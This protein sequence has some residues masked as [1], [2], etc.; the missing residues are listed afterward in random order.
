MI[1]FAGQLRWTSL[2]VGSKSNMQ[3]S[4]LPYY[5][6]FCFALPCGD[7]LGGRF[8]CKSTALL[9]GLSATLWQCSGQ[10]KGRRRRG[11]TVPGSLQSQATAH[12]PPQI[13]DNHSG[14]EVLM[15]QRCL[16]ANLPSRAR[17]SPEIAAA[18]NLLLVLTALWNGPGRISQNTKNKAHMKPALTSLRVELSIVSCCAASRHISSIFPIFHKVRSLDL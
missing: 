16:L 1:Q 18:L 7:L 3:W 13:R 15:L 11:G 17:I 14:A 10:R 4:S 8:K 5:F 6:G 12:W 2:L 9:P